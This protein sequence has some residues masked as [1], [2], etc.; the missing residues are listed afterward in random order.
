[1]LDKQIY[2]KWA[3]TAYAA[4]KIK[5]SNLDLFEHNRKNWSEGIAKHGNF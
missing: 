2:M 4:L 1:M 3:H 5:M